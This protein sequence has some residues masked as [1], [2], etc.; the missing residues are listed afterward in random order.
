MT[1]RLALGLWVCALAGEALGQARGTAPA[2]LAD[3]PA[4]VAASAPAEMGPADAALAAASLYHSATSLLVS[5]SSTAA[6]AGRLVALSEMAYRLDGADPRIN[7]LL[8]DLRQG[9]QQ[10]LPAAGHA[11]CRRR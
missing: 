10:P 1:L 4:G 8:A 11:A 2:V 5:P 3:P 7:L 6:R 9:Q